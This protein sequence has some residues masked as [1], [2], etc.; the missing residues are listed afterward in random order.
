VLAAPAFGQHFLFLANGVASLR[1]R[2]HLG[3]ANGGYGLG[4]MLFEQMDH[5]LPRAGRAVHEDAR[6]DGQ[7]PGDAAHRQW[8]KTPAKSGQTL[9]TQAIPE[10]A[11]H[12][13][14]SVD[15]FGAG[16]IADDVS[17]DLRAN[18]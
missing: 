18:R 8:A 4:P 2:V 17:L 1:F 12:D 10:S 6:D 3:P 5:V 9:G 13:H 15:V 11:G 14:Q 16:Q 7:R